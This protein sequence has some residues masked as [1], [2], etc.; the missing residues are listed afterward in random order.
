MAVDPEIPEHLVEGWKAFE[1]WRIARERAGIPLPPG[2][3]FVL[4]KHTVL[5]DAIGRYRQQIANRLH[6]P[7]VCVKIDL[8]RDDAGRLRPVTDVN[9][10]EG[11][12]QRWTG[13]HGG[14]R[15]EDYARQHIQDVLRECYQELQQEILRR[16]AGLLE[17][18]QDLLPRETEDLLGQNEVQEAGLPA[19]RAPEVERHDGAGG[20]AS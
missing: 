10:P 20:P 9:P 3:Y 8:D 1:D 18:R 6:L 4:N 14:T 11:W 12:L 19:E 7:L 15:V 17:D 13:G 5:K 2:G 16:V